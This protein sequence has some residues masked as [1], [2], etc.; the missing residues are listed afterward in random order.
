VIEQVLEKKGTSPQ[1]YNLNIPTAAL[2]GDCQLRVVPMDVAHYGEQFE[3]RTDP[4]G[5]DYYW[6]T[7][8]PPPPTTRHETDL[9]AVTKGFIALSPLGFDMTKQCALSDMQSWDFCFKD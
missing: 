3:K 9:S 5:R 1:L 8:M 6:S 4:W 7:A 2:E